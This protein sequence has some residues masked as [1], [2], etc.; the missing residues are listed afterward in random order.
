MLIVSIVSTACSSSNTSEETASNEVL[1][2]FLKDKPE[3]VQ[4]IYANAAQNKELLENIR[5]YCGCGESTGDKNNYDCFIHENKRDGKVVWDDH[6]T[7]CGVCL[8]IAAQ[9]VPDLE[10][11]KSIKQIRQSIDEKY[12]SGYA[13]PTPT[14]EV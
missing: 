6:G 9:S 14:P 11:G 12:K 7:K 4:T 3:E 8:E 10:S 13:K 1:P 5:Y 2:E